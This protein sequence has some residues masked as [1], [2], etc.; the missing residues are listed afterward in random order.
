MATIDWMIRGPQISTCNCDFSCPCQFNALPTR[1]D[2]R[3]TIAMEIE[4][5]HFGDTDLSGV[6]WAASAAWPGAIH[7]GHGEIQAVIDESTS[8]AQRD[9]LL[10][11]LAGRETEPGATIFNVF[12]AVL[13]TIHHPLFLPIRFQ[14][15][16][17][18][19]T[20]SFAIEGF[21]KGSVEPIRNPVT[22]APH[23]A[24]VT[25][26][27]GFEYH[28]AEFVSSTTRAEG[29]ISHDWAGRHGHL[30]MLHMTPKGPVHA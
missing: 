28:E 8:E 24:R 7:E 19:G 22:G 23:R 25:L 4:E 21:A 10:T 14:A 11:I 9:G 15:D 13:E 18:K 29:L 30:A 17:A 20:G 1:G 5:G 12:A 2:C 16:I 3:A 6:R 26:P 27:E